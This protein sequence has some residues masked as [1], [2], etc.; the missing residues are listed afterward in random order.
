MQAETYMISQQPGAL[1][2]TSL[3]VYDWSSLVFS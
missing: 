1:I 3:E 2:N